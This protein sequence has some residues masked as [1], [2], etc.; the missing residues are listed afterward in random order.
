M[1]FTPVRQ[2]YSKQ[3]VC[4]ICKSFL[5]QIQTVRLA[6]KATLPPCKKIHPSQP[7][8]FHHTPVWLSVPAQ[9]PGPRAAHSCEESTGCPR[10]CPRALQCVH[11]AGWG[12][13]EQSSERLWKKGLEKT[14][15]RPSCLSGRGH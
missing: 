12:K 8:S 5:S 4:N 7:A 9:I 6:P 3:S 13:Q 1:P 15:L 14:M 10:C 11:S 2:F